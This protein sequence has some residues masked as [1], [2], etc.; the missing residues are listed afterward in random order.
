[1]GARA[2]VP[3]SFLGSSLANRQGGSSSLST[4][5]RRKPQSDGA[6][7]MSA[8]VL[9]VNTKGG[10]HGHIGLH[11]AR[12]LLDEGNKVHIHQ[13]GN[14]QSSAPIEQYPTLASSYPDSFSVDFG[15]LPSSYTGEYSAIYDNNAKSF[16]DIA[17][18]IEASRSSGAQ[19]FYVSSAGAYSYDANVAPHLEGGGAT[20][21]T[22]EVEAAIRSAG[23]SSANFRPIYIIGPHTSK[24]EYVDFFFDRLVR[25]RPVPLP[26]HGEELTSIT[27][28]RD[29]ADLLAGA[30]GKPLRDETI[31]CANTRAI[32]FDAMVSLCA[33]ACGVEGKTFK[34]NPVE[35]AK[36]IDGFKV[37]KAFPFRPRHF[38]ADPGKA[39]DK[40]GWEPQVSG[41]PEGIAASIKECYEEYVKLGL[42]K[43]EVDFS[44]DDKIMEA[45][46]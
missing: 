36:R 21:P 10:G 26:G 40:L 3:S 2:F 18:A 30:L 24:R 20:G 13:V 22:I 33:E 23:V 8:N 34:Y 5:P 38:F 41:T 39:Q 32:S 43:A 9:I 7:C 29:I 37:K 44:L 11:L 1:M 25:N 16:D 12:K 4:N 45:M 15:D 42:D 35:A 19:L 27:D 14:A 6:P 46:K 31:N 28:V 17:P